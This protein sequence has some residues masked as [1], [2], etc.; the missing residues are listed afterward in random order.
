MD[1]WPEFIDRV[2]GDVQPF[3]RSA[4]VATVAGIPVFLQFLL[5][6]PGTVFD[7]PGEDLE[8]LL[9]TDEALGFSTVVLLQDLGDPDIVPEPGPITDFCTPL[10]STNVAYG[11]VLDA[12]QDGTANGILRSGF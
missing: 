8:R 12:D 5:F 6:N 2:I 11:T 10:T 4:G 9:P 7:L 3:R 1:H